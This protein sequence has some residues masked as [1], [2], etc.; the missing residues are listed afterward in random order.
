[1]DL[2]PWR[3][4]SAAGAWGGMLFHKCIAEGKKLLLCVSVLE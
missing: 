3:G 1:M 2:K 4:G